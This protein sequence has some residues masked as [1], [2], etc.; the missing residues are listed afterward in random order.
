MDLLATVRKEGSRGG[1]GEFK[2]SDV[3]SSSHRENYLGHSLMAPVGRWQKG[4]D[5]TWY[6]KGD[7]DSQG[8]ED[9][10]AKAARERKEEIQ[11]VKQA[12]EDALARAL[13]LPVPQRSNPNLD[14]L[15]ARREVDN[16]LKEAAAGEDIASPR[17]VG[18]GR[19]ARVSAP[20][21]ATATENT[22]AAAGVD[23]DTETA[24]KEDIGMTDIDI[25]NANLDPPGETGLTDC[26]QNHLH[27]LENV[28]VIVESGLEAP[29]H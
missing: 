21:A 2:W 25:E 20:S 19:T 27:L 10:A 29:L 17:G 18:Y 4:R 13:G 24:T 9:A 11:R 22:E 16:V 1:R 6:A 7:A 28:I 12:E 8:D 3:E 14:E 23:R 15:G 26:D 5:L